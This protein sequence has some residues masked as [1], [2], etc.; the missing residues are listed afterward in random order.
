MSDTRITVEQWLLEGDG[1]KESPGLNQ[2]QR[3]AVTCARNVVT[4]AGAGA[5]KTFVLARRYAYMVCVRHYKVSEILTLTFTRKATAEMY[6]R[7]YKTLRTIAQTFGS[8]Q[9]LQAVAEFHTARIQ[10]LDSYC[11]SII[12]NSAHHYGIK[13][14]FTI[15][16]EKARAMAG[17]Q[18]L[19]F[20]LAH[21]HHPAIQLMAHTTLGRLDNLA[22]ELFAHTITKYSTLANPIDFT[23]DFAR[24]LEALHRQFGSLMGKI[25]GQVHDLERILDE[26][27]KL[28]GSFLPKLKAAVED[29]RRHDWDFA[30]ETSGDLVHYCRAVAK[31]ASLSLQGQKPDKPWPA[32]I[33]EMREHHQNLCAIATVLERRQEVRQLARLLEDFQAEYNRSKRLAGILTFAD[34]AQLALDTLK[35]HPEVRQ[36]EQEGCKA[37]MI[38]E[39]Q[40]DNKLQKDL[41]YLLAAKPQAPESG[42]PAECASGSEHGS[43]VQPGIP[44]VENLDAGKL[45][46]VG[47]E[48]QSIYKFRGADVSVFRGLAAE[49]ARGNAEGGTLSLSYNYRSH[50]RLIAAFNTIFGGLPYKHGGR[51]FRYPLAV[52]M[53]SNPETPHYEATYQEVLAGKEM[54]AGEDNEKRRV[55]LCLYEKPAADASLPPMEQPL[56]P[57]ECEAFFVAKKIAELVASG[58]DPAAIAILL[59][60]TTKQHHYESYLKLFGIPYT[61]ESTVGFF[62]DA[63]T[64]DILSF[65][66]LCLYPGDSAAYSIV[67]RS[68]FVGLSA[69]GLETLLASGSPT[70]F[71]PADARLLS[72]DAEKQAFLQACATYHQLAEQ[73]PAMAI[74]ELVSTLWYKLGY[75]YNTLE[76]KVTEQYAPLYDKLFHLA[77]QAESAGTSL[78]RF[79]QS[80][81]EQVDNQGKIDDLDIPLEQGDGVRLMTIHKSK[82]LEFPVVFLV[83]S[84]AASRGTKND[85]CVYSCQDF[86]LTYNVPSLPQLG[87]SRA[88]PFYTQAKTEEA[89]K[90]VAERRRLLYV[91]L[92]RAE[93]EVYITATVGARDDKD[94]AKLKQGESQDTM[95]KLLLPQVNCH[96][97]LAEQIT[98]EADAPFDAEWIPS[99]CRRDVEAMKLSAQGPAP[100]PAAESG[101]KPRRTLTARQL[102]EILAPYYQ[103]EAVVPAVEASPYR[104]PSHLA[105]ESPERW[106]E[107]SAKASP[108]AP[109]APQ[110]Y[111]EIAQLVDSTKKADGEPAFTYAD[112]GSCAHLYLEAALQNREPV[113]PTKYLQH[114]SEGRRKKLHQLCS[115][116]A[117]QFLASATGTEVL[118]AQWR[119]TEF[120][121][122]LRL[123]TCIINGTM[124]LLYQDQDG[125]L[126]ILD[127]KTDQEERPEHYYPQQAA[128]RK[129]AAAIF[130]QPEEAITCGLYYLRSGRT[131]DISAGCATV[132]L[133]ELVKLAE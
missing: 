76:K 108:Q 27:P 78:A 53:E 37:I 30:P 110:A 133:E 50:P 60:T 82:G 59:A 61:A 85:E 24:Q 87:S 95:F 20:V 71:N 4:A 42:R 55:H 128:Y 83:N 54:K 127:Y 56:H 57:T 45:F 48:K 77:A 104:T 96:L 7:I 58:R 68:P 107:P 18:A 113:I 12:K 109:V 86:G 94:S 46:F 112:F 52:F 119:K 79:V 10:T 75:R 28:T 19:P 129:A 8:P 121:F 97:N 102:A 40:D 81:Q 80:L 31:I 111:S 115:T 32:I 72:A 118:A 6:S 131:V 2:E 51:R 1:T 14:D 106:H 74:T 38:D 47:D 100:D 103:G 44:S 132:N 124:D 16:D 25:E 39:F 125:G 126:H 33:R 21:R 43:K 3:A 92:T 114:L 66:T 34:A 90:E 65:L 5:G 23:S 84:N 49:L 88:N 73:A 22:Q 123:G 99:V 36:A 67:L 26:L 70:I 41:L 98:V 105:P 101:G 13:P 29:F 15:D 116:M 69:E 17:Q 35:N 91:A 63:P 11:S 64:N 9:A 120:P 122:K 117:Q 130:N 62:Q 89:A 93:Q